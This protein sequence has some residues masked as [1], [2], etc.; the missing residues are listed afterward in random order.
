MTPPR[1]RRRPRHGAPAQA[2]RAPAAAAAELAA[3]AATVA[4]PDEPRCRPS[5]CHRSRCRLRR[6]LRARTPPAGPPPAPDPSGITSGGLTRRVRGAQMPAT[7][8]LSL[9]RSGGDRPPARLGPAARRAALRL[10]AA[11][12]GPPA[13]AAR[14]AAAGPGRRRLTRIAPAGRRRLQLPQQLH[15][16]GPAR[17][18]SQRQ[19]A[20]RARA[21]RPPLSGRSSAG[22]GAG[23]RPRGS[24]ELG[25]RAPE[26]AHRLLRPLLVLDQGE[27]HVALAAGAEADARRQRHLRL[28]HQHGRE[29]DRAHLA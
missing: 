25:E 1:R 27:A 22:R 20:A 12:I 13:D 6:R 28:A 11:A 9:R 24:A 26:V 23:A 3:A 18:R 7:Q 4:R 14:R 21:R 17:P 19:P 10:A 2:P 29:L 5:P 8:P 15:R 16:G